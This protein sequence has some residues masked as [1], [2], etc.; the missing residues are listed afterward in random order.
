[1]VAVVAG[2]TISTPP[3]PSSGLKVF[4]EVAEVWEADD[5]P[6]LDLPELE[7]LLVS[8]PESL[9]DGDAELESEFD[10]SEPDELDADAVDDDLGG[11]VGEGEALL[12]CL[13]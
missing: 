3:G 10:E 5:F 1:M 13:L 12:S 7:A 8:L 4:E 11:G 9:P 2:L 6:E